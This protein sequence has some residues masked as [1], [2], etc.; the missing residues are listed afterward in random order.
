[1]TDEGIGHMVQLNQL[2]VYNKLTA[3]R[4]KAKN[5]KKSNDRVKFVELRH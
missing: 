1:M 2:N 3:N 4:R 5:A